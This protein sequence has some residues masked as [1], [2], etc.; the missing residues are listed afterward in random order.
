MF[1]CFISGS[2]PSTSSPSHPPHPHFS[3]CIPQLISSLFLWTFTSSL[4]IYCPFV[5][6]NLVSIE[7]GHIFFFTLHSE[8]NGHWDVYVCFCSFCLRSENGFH[9]LIMYTCFIYKCRPISRK[10]VYAKRGIFWGYVQIVE[11]DLVSAK[12]NRQISNQ[13]TVNIQV[14]S[15]HL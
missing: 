11:E 12:C 14:S 9:T 5:L 7:M 8:F 10:L 15:L 3:I 13:N 1:I 2:P 4:Y 6:Y